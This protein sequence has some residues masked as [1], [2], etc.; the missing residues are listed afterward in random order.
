MNEIVVSEIQVI[1]I[2]PQNGLVAFASC[3]INDQFYIGNIGIHTR[4]DGSGYRLV[5]PLKIL[6]NGKAIQ[7]F[8]PICRWA[9]DQI[10]TAI[11]NKLEK[12]IENIKNKEDVSTMSRQTGGNN[13][14]ESRIP[15]SVVP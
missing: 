15:R 7:C 11:I 2:K 14:Y 10:N 12:L 5:F 9:G 6:P 3:V 8:H 1:P 4:A 13:N